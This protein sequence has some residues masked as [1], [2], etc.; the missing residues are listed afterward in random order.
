MKIR[1]GRPTLGHLAGS[2]IGQALTLA[3]GSESMLAGE[4]PTSIAMMRKAFSTKARKDGSVTVELT[5]PEAW[6][7]EVYVST[8]VVGA[9]ENID[10]YDLAGSSW[11]LAEIN[12]GRAVLRALAKEG[13]A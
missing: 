1:I 5:E 11:A 8:M 13:I 9:A 6:S 12:S 3:G 7:L 10:G 2:G 4:D